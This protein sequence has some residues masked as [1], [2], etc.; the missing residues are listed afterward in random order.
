M[1]AM[2]L[3]ECRR[4]M[5]DLDEQL[6]RLLSDRARVSLQVAK[7]KRAMG[8]VPAF[9]PE[10]ERQ[11]FNHVHQVNEG[12]LPNEALDA[13]WREI[14]SSSRALQRTLRVAYAESASAFAQVAAKRYFG[15]APEYVTC[16]TTELVF[17]ETDRG[18]ADYG[19][20]P[21][22]HSLEGVVG[23]TI[24]H[25]VD[26]ELKIRAEVALENA[27]HLSSLGELDQVRRIYAAVETVR[28]VRGWLDEHLPAVEIHDVPTSVRAAERAGGDP[29]SAAICP[30]LIASDHG[31]QIVAP[32]IQDST[33]DVTRFLVIGREIGGRSGADKTALIFSVRDRVGALHDALGIF[34]RN[35]LNLTRIESRPSRR[36]A[37]DYLFFV[38]LG[39]HPDDDNV[40]TALKELSYQTA[41]VKV[42]GAWPRES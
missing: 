26:S 37:W 18:A 38:E 6:V 33:A 17:A 5:D 14:L 3:E 11:V 16:R 4:R 23:D 31:L 36:R 1:E 27:Y 7:A 30:D 22:E 20:V 13:I 25:F 35:S 29:E 8:S 12:P 42:L 39:G 21:V 9:V 24:D 40:A 28:Q 15:A 2:T 19:V 34:R 10:R 41:Y 32:S